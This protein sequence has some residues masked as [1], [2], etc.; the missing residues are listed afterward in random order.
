MTAGFGIALVE[1]GPT[2]I[3]GTTPGA[4]NV[5]SGGPQSADLGPEQNIVIFSSDGDGADTIQGNIIGLDPTGTFAITGDT[6]GILI[7]DIADTL[8]GGSVPGAGNLISGNGGDG[9]EVYGA[10]GTIIQGNYI[11]TDVTGTV[12]IPN[13][14]D[15][16]QPL[17]ASIPSSEDQIPA[18]ET[19]SRTI[20]A[21]AS[22]SM[23]P[24]RTTPLRATR[25][26]PMA[27][28]ASSWKVTTRAALPLP[29][30]QR[31]FP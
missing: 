10:S 3:G 14:G 30:T 5:I 12:A 19:W 8:I 29:A 11:G 20:L 1:A 27:I 22:T 25:S 31:I 2:L 9:I 24:H 18:M 4:G 15:W 23:T 7:Y 13:S 6:G 21:T 28:S 26:S 16:H 17:G